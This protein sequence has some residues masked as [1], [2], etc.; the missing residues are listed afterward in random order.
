MG[1]HINKC[2]KSP[3]NYIGPVHDTHMLL[4]YTRRPQ[5]TP[6]GDA[7]PRPLAQNSSSACGDCS[8][9]DA[10][11]SDGLCR[12][13]PLCQWCVETADNV[14]CECSSHLHLLG[15]GNDVLKH[16]GNGNDSLI[17]ACVSV[18]VVGILAAV[19]LWSRVGGV[20]EVNWLLAAVRS[21]SNDASQLDRNMMAAQHARAMRRTTVL[22][23]LVV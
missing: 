18:A 1:C 2:P 21:G 8:A 22:T 6:T 16:S 11:C 5:D 17:V 15:D 19:M 14:T 12:V 9:R 10:Q 7:E 4:C 20:P 13:Y 23:K 3:L